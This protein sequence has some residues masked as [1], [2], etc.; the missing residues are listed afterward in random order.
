M[1]KLISMFFAGLIILLPAAIS[2]YLIYWL[3]MRIDGILGP[4]LEQVW[5]YA[6]PG[7]G[8]II[9]ITLII[10]VGFMATNIIGRKLFLW[11]EGILIKI[12]LLGKLYSTIK[13]ITRSFLS[14]NKVSFKK[15]VLVEFPRIG[16][17]SI[18]FITNDEFPFLEE[19]SYSI[20]VPTT[21]NPTSGFFIVVPRDKVK[22]LDISVDQAFEIIMSAGMITE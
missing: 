21:P 4:L 13:K 3:F 1:K 20:F 9:T 2:L 11:W 22:I 16:A 18:G 17:H 14:P 12:P 15:V 7:I 8:F 10:I 6:I 5:G 19:N